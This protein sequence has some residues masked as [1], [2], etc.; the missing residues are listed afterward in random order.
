MEKIETVAVIGGGISGL[1]VAWKLKRLGKRVRLFEASDRVG[2]VIKTSRIEGY[3]HEEGPNEMLIK[4]AEVEA[5]IKDE[6]G[7]SSVWRE[8]DKRANK[9]YILKNGRPVAVP[10]SPI[11]FA[12]TPLFSVGAKFKLLGEP[13]RPR[14]NPEV[15]ESVASFFK[16]RMGREFVDYAIAPLITGIYAGDVERLSM[17][18]VF[19][20]F[21]EL[22]QKHGS[23]IKAGLKGG[24]KRYKPKMVTFENGMQTVTDALA[25]ALEEE[26]VTE[27]RLTAIDERWEVRGSAKSSDFS[28]KYDAL[29]CAVLANRLSTLPWT[30][31]IRACL[32]PLYDMPYAPV[33][34]LFLGFK[35]EQIEHPLDG[36]GMLIPAVEK[37]DILGVIFFSSLF[38]NRAPE[39]FVSLILFL[40]GVD[41]PDM[42]HMSEKDV[43]PK[44]MGELSK[45][46][47]VKGDPV[48]R[49]HT[50]WPEA[51][52][53]YD[54]NQD[55]RL[56][57]LKSLEVSHPGLYFIGNY[58]DG[59]GAGDC[60]YNGIHTAEKLARS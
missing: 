7:L 53:Q 1:S 5:L 58:R 3:L 25:K 30:R 42:A 48:F 46:L 38:P 27:A 54:L 59:V 12:T 51:I 23:L 6:L 17:E 13:F 16:R 32:G 49:K 8:P 60:I 55:L 10:M 29:V 20:R 57:A 31:G 43:L 9:R 22:E 21:H 15:V 33:S 36:F 19:P 41:R 50:Y 52:P 24:A 2:G 40:G 11:S 56:D 37:R 47:G 44:V 35:G 4:Q 45:M 39:D 34:T 14:G 18:H 28:E 26:I